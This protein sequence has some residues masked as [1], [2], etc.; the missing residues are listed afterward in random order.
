MKKADWYFDFISPFA[1]IGLIRL[2]RL[3]QQLETRYRPV[4]FAGLL[5]TLGTEGTSG[6]S[7]QARLTRLSPSRATVGQSPSQRMANLRARL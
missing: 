5:N 1:Y 7:R 4:L 3:S 6:D 2:G